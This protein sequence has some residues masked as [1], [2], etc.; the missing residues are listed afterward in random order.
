V[1]ARG[2]DLTGTFGVYEGQ[3]N[4]NQLRNYQFL[5][6]CSMRQ[7]MERN[8]EDMDQKTEQITIAYNA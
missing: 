8:L 3:T 5:N 4:V 2:L 6:D 7:E 1:W